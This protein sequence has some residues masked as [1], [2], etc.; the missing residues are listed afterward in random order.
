MDVTVGCPCPGTPHPDG[1]TVTLRDKPNF[2]MG[3]MALGWAGRQ[4][5]DDIPTTGEIMELYLR[6]GI[7]AWTFVLEDGSPRAVDDE[8]LDWLLDDYELAY[9]IADEA[10]SLY[11]DRIF[12]PLLK[13]T[14][15][16]SQ[17]GRT[18]RSTYRNSRRSSK[19]QSPSTP[20]S[21]GISE[22]S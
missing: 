9:P 5:T 12:A 3:T 19:V 7:T 16:S 10:A 6:D 14:R 22:A 15:N 2:H 4:A 18:G 17:T 11:T 13:Q 1:D 20:S 21:T 8:G